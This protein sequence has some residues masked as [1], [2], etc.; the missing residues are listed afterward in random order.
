MPVRRFVSRFAKLFVKPILIS[1]PRWNALLALSKGGEPWVVTAQNGLAY[2]E[3]GGNPE[4]ATSAEP[5]QAQID[6]MVDG[7][8]ARLA[9]EGGTVDEWTQLVRSRMVQGRRA[10]R[11]RP[12]APAR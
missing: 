1:A 12:R 11:P 6:A 5:D 8:A 2:A 7:L 9:S 3:S 10:G 4:A